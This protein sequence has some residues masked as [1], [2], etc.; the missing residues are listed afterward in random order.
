MVLW[1]SAVSPSIFS[2]KNWRTQAFQVSL[3]KLATLSPN[4]LHSPKICYV[5]CRGQNYPKSSRCWPTK[6][7]TVGRW[8][9]LFCPCFLSLRWPSFWRLLSG[10]PLPT[11]LM[12]SRTDLSIEVTSRSVFSIIK[13]QFR[14]LF[15]PRCFTFIG[16]ELHLT[17]LCPLTQ[18][19]KSFWTSLSLL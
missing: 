16:T 10:L 7:Y 13:T 14:F 4:S 9:L 11:K 18:I 12:I 5:L 8:E 3:Y 17:C 1:I 6:S 15:F 19:F 2:F